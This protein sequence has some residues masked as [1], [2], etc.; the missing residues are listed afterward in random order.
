MMAEENEIHPV[1]D[2]VTGLV[3][4]LNQYSQRGTVPVDLGGI[5]PDGD[6][7]DVTAVNEQV[8]AGEDG[9]EENGHDETAV[10]DGETW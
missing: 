8:P 9:F 10:P 7:T 2:G 3:E 6:Q 1:S 4:N 5:I